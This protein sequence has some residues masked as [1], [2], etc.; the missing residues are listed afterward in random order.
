MKRS[1]K[2]YEGQRRHCCWCFS[3][4]RWQVIRVVVAGREKRAGHS[5]GWGQG[6]VAALKRAGG[7]H[8]GT[9]QM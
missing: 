2:I 4:R 7:E 5:P 6:W 9:C 1:K 8:Q 3:I